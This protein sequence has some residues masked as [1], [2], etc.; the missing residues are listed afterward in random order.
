MQ[1]DEGCYARSAA[2]LGSF[3]ILIVKAHHAWHN[4]LDRTQVIYLH[5]QLTVDDVI[6]FDYID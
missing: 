4:S 6:I 2:F 3:F 1:H 5:K